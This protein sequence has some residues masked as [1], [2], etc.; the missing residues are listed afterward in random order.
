[1]AAEDSGT[2][3]VLG[4]GAVGLPVGFWS[5]LI[6]GY[7][8]AGTVSAWRMAREVRLDLKAEKSRER[9]GLD[10]QRRK[11][12]K[13]RWRSFHRLKSQYQPLREA[14]MLGMAER[15]AGGGM[16]GPTM[17]GVLVRFA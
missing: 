10:H 13:M 5:A 17:F 3:S 11:P 4:G 7:A 12:R 6:A 9:L 2:Q 14:S 8:G 1:M 15:F 16:K